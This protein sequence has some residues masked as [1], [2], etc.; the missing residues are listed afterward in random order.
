[1]PAAPSTMPEELPAWWMCSIR[2]RC[3]YFIIATLSKPGMT[4]PIA[5]N[6]ASSA[7]SFCMSVS[8]RMYS[9]WA[10]MVRPLRSVTG[11]TERANRPSSQAALARFWRPDGEGVGLDRG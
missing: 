11:T 3:G 4:S 10:R 8:G 7:P 2:S 9:S 6:E 1:M 5:R